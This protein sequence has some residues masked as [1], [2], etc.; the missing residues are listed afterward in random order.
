MT[1]QSNKLKSVR[2]VVLSFGSLLA[3]FF[4]L[5]FLP[6]IIMELIGDSP[7][8]AAGREWEGQVMI[9]TFLT[10][11][12]GYGIGWWRTFWGGVIIVLAAF[13]VTIPFITLQSNYGSLI[14]GIPLL[15]VGLLY[16]LLY[17]TEKQEKIRKK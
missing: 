10:L 16:L 9:A 13:V 6:K 8:V 4:L 14:F 2:I 1:E 7:K 11:L 17:L 15:F 12:I 3:L 5:A